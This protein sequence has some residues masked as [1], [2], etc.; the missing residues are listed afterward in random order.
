[1]LTKVNQAARTQGNFMMSDNRKFDLGVD[2]LSG[3]IESSGF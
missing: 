1:M 3:N 2:D